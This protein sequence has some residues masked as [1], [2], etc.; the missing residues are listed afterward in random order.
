[1]KKNINNFFQ[2][3]SVLIF[4]PIFFLF[5][6]NIRICNL[7][8][9]PANV[10]PDAA[11]TLQRYL[12]LKYENKFNFFDFNW[13]GVQAFNSYIIGNSWEIFGRFVFVLRFPAV[14]FS[15][16]AVATLF[17]PVFYLQKIFLFN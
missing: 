10:Q 5:S 3:F 2:K 13:N 16:L 6:L 7:N 17:L 11:D 14:L 4:A 9:V 15:S 1:M 8:S 12:Q